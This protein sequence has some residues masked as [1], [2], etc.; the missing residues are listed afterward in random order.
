MPDRLDFG[1]YDPFEDVEQGDRLLAEVESG[2]T[3]DEGVA[4]LRAEGTG[5]GL[6]LRI[7]REEVGDLGAINPTDNGGADLNFRDNV[8][9]GDS[10]GIRQAVATQNQEAD[11]VQFERQRPSGRFAP[12]NVQRD[13]SVPADRADDGRFVSK[14]RER[15]LDFGR[16]PSDGLFE[17][18]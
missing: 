12:E 15:V 9:G 1:A 14:D 11:P 5:S 2:D 18:F 6:G 17:S 13:P 7:G 3:L 16:D 4:D 8:F 10:V